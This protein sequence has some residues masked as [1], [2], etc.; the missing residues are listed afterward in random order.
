MEAERRMTARVALLRRGRHQG[1]E[2]ELPRRTP[3]G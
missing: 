3:L 2:A 1:I